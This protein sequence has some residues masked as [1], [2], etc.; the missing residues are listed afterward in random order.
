MTANLLKGA[1]DPA[2][3]A[4]LL[5]KF[6]PD[7]LVTQEL[8]DNAASVIA[9]HFR[10]RR[11][12]P[13]SDYLGRGVASRHPAELVDIPLPHRPGVGVIVP[14]GVHRLVV[15]GIHL[16]NPVSFPWWR[17]AEKR[18]EQ[19]DALESWVEDT[20]ES[21]DLIV[22]AGD[23][24]ASPRWP[25]YR[26]LSERYE[27]LVIAAGD[28][29]APTWAWRPGWPRLLRID[30]VFGRGVQALGSSVQSVLG[31]DH[32]ALIVDVEAP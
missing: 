21:S 32:A 16:L 22:I 17:I 10:F 30:H 15:A 25:A 26:R 7:V 28:S 31:S 6:N 27:D 18:G 5:E 4:G 11:L 29:P 24:N 19:L 12:N 23:M 13:S 1:A 14:I 20:A 2:H 8:G 9:D 3:F